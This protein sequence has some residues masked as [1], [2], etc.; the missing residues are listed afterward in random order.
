[1]NKGKGYDIGGNAVT[2]I[3]KKK[4]RRKYKEIG[5]EPRD[6]LEFK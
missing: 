2:K 6:Q 5:E 3:K 1:M 4:K